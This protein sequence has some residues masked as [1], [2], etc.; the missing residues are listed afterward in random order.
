MKSPHPRGTDLSSASSPMR[1]SMLVLLL[2]IIPRAR[3]W[4]WQQLVVGCF[5]GGKGRKGK[6]KQPLVT[7]SICAKGKKINGNKRKHESGALGSFRRAESRA[8]VRRWGAAGGSSGGFG[9]RRDIA[10]CLCRSLR[11][12]RGLRSKG[13]F[14]LG[15]CFWACV[16]SELSNYGASLNCRAL[17]NY[18][19]SY[20]LRS[21][22][23]RAPGGLGIT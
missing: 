16:L 10:G 17:P 20:G 18:Q 4:A 5:L 11:A 8:A 15:R 21:A 13:T 7:S 19:T 23:R 12:G 2:S 22:A 3:S 6:E 1:V 9:A 14:G